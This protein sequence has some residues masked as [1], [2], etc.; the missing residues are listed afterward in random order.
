MYPEAIE[1]LLF[2]NTPLPPFFLF[3]SSSPHS[4]FFFSPSLIL[5][6]SA[7]PPSP[8]PLSI[9]HFIFGVSCSSFIPRLLPTGPGATWCRLGSEERDFVT[10][11]ECNVFYHLLTLIFHLTLSIFWVSCLPF[12]P[13]LLPTGPGETW[14]RLGSEERDVV[15]MSVLHFVLHLFSA[16]SS[17]IYLAIY[18]PFPQRWLAPHRGAGVQ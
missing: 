17:A 2:I 6:L 11:L 12:I 5:R 18:M 1:T 9:L 7:P 3:S 8:L 16:T 13:R 15:T 4:S 10:M 14:C